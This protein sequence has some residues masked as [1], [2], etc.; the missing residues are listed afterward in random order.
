MPA[1]PPTLLK[2]IPT[3]THVVGESAPPSLSPQVSLQ[4]L[5]ND[6]QTRLSERL[7]HVVDALVQEQL[8]ALR[9][10]LRE[11][12]QA[13]IQEALSET[14]ALPTKAMASTVTKTYR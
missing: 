4:G 1:I 7:V 14:E 5:D 12:I 10:V 13:V 3:L 2:G 6:V 11:R 8:N 9:P